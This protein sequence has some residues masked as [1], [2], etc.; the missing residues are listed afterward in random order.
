MNEATPGF[1]RCVHKD[2]G[3]QYF[4]KSTTEKEAWQKSTG[5]TPQSAPEKET[6][7]VGLPHKVALVAEPTTA[8]NTEAATQEPE[9]KTKKLK[10][11]A[12]SI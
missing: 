8:E 9:K 2:L 11:T 6:G 1:V 3:V 7:E 4:R 5:W 12:D 10:H